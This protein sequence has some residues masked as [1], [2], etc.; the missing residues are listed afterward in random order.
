MKV[1]EVLKLLSLQ[2]WHIVRTRG[3]HRQLKNDCHPGTVTVAGRKTKD[4]H[5]VIWLRIQQQA[6]LRK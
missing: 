6:G 2:G 1:K 4:L 5:P 3:S